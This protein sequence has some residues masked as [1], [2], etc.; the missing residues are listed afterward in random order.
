M[1]DLDAYKRARAIESEQSEKSGV[2]FEPR[3]HIPV[4]IFVATLLAGVIIVKRIRR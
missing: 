1:T 3:T 2:Y 4:L